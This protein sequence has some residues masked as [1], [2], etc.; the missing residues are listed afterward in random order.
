[1]TRVLDRAAQI[2]HDDRWSSAAAERVMFPDGFDRDKAKQQIIDFAENVPADR[3]EERR[4]DR[5]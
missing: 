4:N 5:R 1:M 3:A 2:G